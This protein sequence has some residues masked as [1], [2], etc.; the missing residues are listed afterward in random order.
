M[1]KIKL[2]SAAVILV[3]FVLAATLFV[4]THN[5]NVATLYAISFSEINKY[6]Q[7]GGNDNYIRGG[8]HKAIGGISTFEI[9]VSKENSVMRFTFTDATDYIAGKYIEYSYSQ[10]NKNWSCI[11]GSIPENFYRIGCAK[12]YGL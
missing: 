9:K 5:K 4:Y 10:E 2:F 6:L 1:S 12:K 8:Y 7:L 3:L 11:G